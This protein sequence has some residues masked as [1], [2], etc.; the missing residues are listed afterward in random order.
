MKQTPIN[1]QSITMMEM[2]F[3]IGEKILPKPTHNKSFF[4]LYAHCAIGKINTQRGTSVW[5]ASNK[6]MAAATKN[7]SALKQV[8]IK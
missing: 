2:P 7:N 4:I 5:V 6:N 1:N 8:I 3:P